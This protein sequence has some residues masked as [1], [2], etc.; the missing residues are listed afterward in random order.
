[1]YYFLEEIK[2]VKDGIQDTIEEMKAL[3]E[4][5]QKDI[6]SLNEI[7]EEIEIEPN[8]LNMPKFKGQVV[9]ERYIQYIEKSKKQTGKM[10]IR[11]KLEKSKILE[12]EKDIN[13]IKQLIKEKE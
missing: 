7:I 5:L 11:G 9:F 10:K 12:N 2:N 3:N 13:K 6:E 4:V 8:I 1:M